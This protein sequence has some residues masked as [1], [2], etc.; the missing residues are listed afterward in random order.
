VLAA[1]LTALGAAVIAFPE[2]ILPLHLASELGAGTAAIGA[3]LGVAAVIAA[4]APPLVGIALR[5]FPPLALATA[6]VMVA[7]AGL[8]S[9][10]VADSVVAIGAALA[11]VA[12]GAD[13]VLT[14]TLALMAD[15]AEAS[16]PPRYGAVYALYTLAYAAGL[17]VAPLVAGVAAEAAGFS[18]AVVGASIGVW[19]ALA[20]LASAAMRRAHLAGVNVMERNAP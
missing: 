18:G 11:L 2:P 19:A 6:G 7:A 5:R 15:L 14:P 8:A 17:T 16:T 13:L 9:L 1:S 10:N 4:I 20:A 3:V 12:L